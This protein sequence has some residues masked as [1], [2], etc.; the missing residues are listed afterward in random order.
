MKAGVYSAPQ[1]LSHR[2]HCSAS[3]CAS[4]PSLYLHA[5]LQLSSEPPRQV[6]LEEQARARLD[7]IP[8]LPAAEKERAL[9]RLRSCLAGPGSATHH[10]ARQQQQQQQQHERQQYI[11][12]AAEMMRQQEREQSVEISQEVQV[13]KASKSKALQR[14]E[15]VA[16][17]TTLVVSVLLVSLLCLVRVTQ[18][19]NLTWQ[20]SSTSRHRPW[21]VEKLWAA[22]RQLSQ[23]ASQTHEALAGVGASS[24]PVSDLRIRGAPRLSL[25]HSVWI[26][27]LFAAADG[28]ERGNVSSAL[29]VRLKNV[30]VVLEVCLPH[31]PE[32]HCVLVSLAEAES[33]RR[34]LWSPAALAHSREWPAGTSVCLKLAGGHTILAFLANTPRSSPMPSANDVVCRFLDNECWYSDAEVRHLVCRRGWTCTHALLMF[35]V[36]HMRCVW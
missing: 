5:S 18:G 26:S 11:S 28:A 33:L 7:N 36:N 10:A 4:P 24:F 29:P 3:L 14:W 35:H 21:S 17:L 1:P 27:T 6:S 13:S 23:P 9:R 31:L 30:N 15:K 2:R 25:P 22:C 12:L 19:T 16:C 32:P 20:A 34:V 8:W